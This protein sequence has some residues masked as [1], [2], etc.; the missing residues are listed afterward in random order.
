MI[1]FGNEVV[2]LVRRVESSANG[3]TR[4]RYRKQRLNGCS[5]RREMRWERNGQALERGEEISCRVPASQTAPRPGDC[6]FRGEISDAIANSADLSAAL[7]AH[8]A[9][10]AFRVASVSDNAAG[11]TPL[12]H[13][14][15][16]GEGA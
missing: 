12:P 3:R 13:Y 9:S 1:P 2:T 16:R 5:W 8:R 10:G 15:A 11:G 6:L 4:I 14:A 7:E